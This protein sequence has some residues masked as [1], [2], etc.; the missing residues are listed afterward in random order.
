MDGSTGAGDACDAP[1]RCQIAPEGQ[2]SLER[3]SALIRRAPL[4]R[5]V[6]LSVGRPCAASCTS[7][8][9]SGS[10]PHLRAIEPRIQRQRAAAETA[11]DWSLSPPRDAAALHRTAWPARRC[12]P[13]LAADTEAPNVRRPHRTRARVLGKKPCQRQCPAR[14]GWRTGVSALNCH[15]VI[16]AAL[17]H[18]SSVGWG[19][20]AAC[21]ALNAEWRCVTMPGRTLRSDGP[22]HVRSQTRMLSHRRFVYMFACLLLGAPLAGSSVA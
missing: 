22:L 3:P 14:L 11:E 18:A 8:Q 6:S 9:R 17:I 16:C 10:A 12:M 21:S 4:H 19:G 2:G 7:G 20:G 5:Y 15:S 13:G 1:Y